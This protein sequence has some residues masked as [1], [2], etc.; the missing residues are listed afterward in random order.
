MSKEYLFELKNSGVI[1]IEEYNHSKSLVEKDGDWVDYAVL[2]T[3]EL[4]LYTKYYK[5][6]I[7]VKNKYDKPEYTATDLLE[8][9][10]HSKSDIK[11]MNEL[12]FLLWLNDKVVCNKKNE[13]I[14]NV[15]F[16]IHRR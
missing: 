2:Y 13:Y 10:I 12:D 9:L 16:D 7:I 15:E 8:L 6:D 5:V 3:T 14:Y 4:E 1:K 11:K